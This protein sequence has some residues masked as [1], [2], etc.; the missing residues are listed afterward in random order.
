[1]DIIVYCLVYI[2]I[3]VTAIMIGIWLIRE[4]MK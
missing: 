2:S 4:K 1:M 3:Q